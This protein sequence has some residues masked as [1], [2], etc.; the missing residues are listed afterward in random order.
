[1]AKDEFVRF[2]HTRYHPYVMD[3]SRKVVLVV[4]DD[5]DLRHMFRDALKFGGFDVREAADGTGALRIIDIDPPDV[6]VLDIRL[7]SLDG[8]SVREEIA[9]NAH[10]R[11]IPVVV[12]TGLQTVDE[13]RLKPVRVLRK[14]VDPTMLLATVRA[15]VAS[16]LAQK[17]G[18]RRDE[19]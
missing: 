2:Q 13:K 1:M 8:Y 15:A 16:V 18:L 4:E 11:N 3:S 12:V 10:T 9:A 7:L 19:V 5:A 17:Y 14:P 6:V